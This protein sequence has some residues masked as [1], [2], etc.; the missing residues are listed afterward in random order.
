MSEQKATREAQKSNPNRGRSQAAAPSREKAG[1]MID[2]KGN[3]QR[4]GNFSGKRRQQ[5][6]AQK[7]R[8]SMQDV[9]KATIKDL[10][11]RVLHLQNTVNELSRARNSTSNV[12]LDAV[13]RQKPKENNGGKSG[14]LESNR[15]L[16]Y[17]GPL[18]KKTG[19]LPNGL[20]AKVARNATLV[21]YASDP[22]T[23]KRLQG[24]AGRPKQ[25]FATVVKASV[26]PK[27]ATS[28]QVKNPNTVSAQ[29]PLCGTPVRNDTPVVKLE[30]TAVESKAKR[31]PKVNGPT[32]RALV[33]ANLDIKHV[34]DPT[35][36][37]EM[38]PLSTARP[39][40]NETRTA[41]KTNVVIAE[42]D[43]VSYLQYE[44]LHVER[45]NKT[46]AKMKAKLDNYFR[47]Y[48]MQNYTWR[49]RVNMASTAIAA[50]MIP[51]PE[52]VVLRNSL[53][54]S[55][56]SSKLLGNHKVNEMKKLNEFVD[57]G[58]LGKT[59]FLGTKQKL[60]TSK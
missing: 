42:D 47:Q 35:F 54:D 53:K 29:S 3:D 9:F 50:A 10:Q 34:E 55:S 51:S 2:K 45:T 12:K 20:N 46:P 38:S 37:A 41:A 39:K 13:T 17:L 25:S 36:V 56:W 30:E 48:D 7:H 40:R 59:W 27:L 15:Q 52:S 57:N 18:P 23:M 33:A 14:S 21:Q 24:G 31:M 1:T 44:F 19:S 16:P 43:L 60:P 6:L 32:K 26:R 49:E 11:Q 5:P 22:G 4:S 8:W 28:P 58:S